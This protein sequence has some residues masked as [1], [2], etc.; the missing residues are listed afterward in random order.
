MVLLFTFVNDILLRMLGMMILCFLILLHHAH[1]LPYKDTRGNTAGSASASAL[2]VIGGINLVRAAF[3]AAEYVPHGPN[4]MLMRV[5]DEV[6]C[7]IRNYIS[8]AGSLRRY[9]HSLHLQSN[10]SRA[11]F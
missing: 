3:E 10:I 2:V 5:F 4:A 8:F 1:A 6:C 11:I 7:S 9:R